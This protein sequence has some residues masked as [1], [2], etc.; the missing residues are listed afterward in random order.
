MDN[1]KI[2]GSRIN[3]ALAMNN[4]LQKELAKQLNV[5]DNIVSYWCKGERTPNTLQ[6]IQIANYLNV[7]TDYLLGVTDVATTDKDLKFVCD[8]TGLEEPAIR[9]LHNIKKYNNNSDYEILIEQ[10]K[11]PHIKSSLNFYYV[12]ISELICELDFTKKICDLYN[13]MGEY[14]F[15]EKNDTDFDFYKQTYTDR[16]DLKFYK[17]FTTFNKIVK[18]KFVKRFKQEFYYKYEQN[19]I[20]E[21]KE[22]RNANMSNLVDPFEHSKVTTINFTKK[23]VNKERTKRK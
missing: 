11:I 7:S 10:E 19:V 1:K 13:T 6:I 22:I 9:N 15:A 12:A 17:L 5:K 3:S 2:I 8:Y 14:N 23:R 20:E 16:L 18:N 21:E 4:T